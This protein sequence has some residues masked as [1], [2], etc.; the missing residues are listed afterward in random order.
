MKHAPSSSAAVCL[1][2]AILPSTFAEMDDPLADLNALPTV[3]PGFEVKV[4]AREPL[5]RQPCSMAFDARGRLFIGM[6][7]QYRNPKPDTPGDSVVMLEDTQGTGVADR[8]K[9]FATGLNTIQALAWHGRDLWI[10]NSPD[11]T[12][13][14]DLDGDD[15]ADEYVRVYTDLG[16]VEH[17]LHGLNWAPDGKLYMSK[18]NSK[19]MNLPDRYAPKPF[20]DLWGLPSPPGAKDLPESQTFTAASYRHT[21]QDPKDDWGQ[22]GGILRCDDLGKNLE[23]FSRGLR[24]PWDIAFDSGFDWLGSDNDQT[25][26]DRIFMPFFGAHFGWGH[27]WSSHWT[28]EGHL[29]TVPI[30]GPVFDGSGTG[31]V[32]YDAPQFPEKFRRV[33]FIN[34]WLRKTMFAYRPR[35]DGALRQPEGGAWQP[36]VVGGKSLFRP[37]D[38]EVGPDGALWCLGWSTGYGAQFK[39]GKLVSEGRVFHIAWKDAPAPKAADK[40]TRPLAQWSA[41]ELIADFAG[42]LPVWRCDAQEEFVRRGAV[43]KADLLAA[44]SGGQLGEAQETWTAW[45]LGRIAPDDTGIESFFAEKLTD[46]KTGLNLRLQ[47]ARI[48]AHRVREFGR[49]MTLPPI[50]EKLLDSPE[51]RLRFAAVQAIAQARQSSFVPAL[52]ALVAHETDRVTF[53]SAWQALR[54]LAGA[55][56]L[57]S[58]LADQRGGVRR[59]ALLALADLAGLTEADVLLMVNDADAPHSRRRGA[60]AGQAW[61]Q[62]A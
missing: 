8:V 36:F 53:F 20:R 15:V 19:G 58:L 5:V 4:F 42:P 30:S 28:G 39:D 61:E 31:I 44:L 46:E 56:T 3:P 7:P 34:D 10:A 37:T 59:A 22:M 52:T 21:F 6:G 25:G 12:I 24:N 11:L 9:V 26:G 62:S 38:L 49:A 27:A 45:T 14:R 23:I 35:W 51:P 57:H 50:F 18:G 13:V 16:N 2:L 41:A 29:P 1:L 55:G 60:V 32:F 17:A 47:A 54:D 48:L 33:F 40:R 43:A